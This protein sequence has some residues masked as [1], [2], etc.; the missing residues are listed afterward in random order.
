MTGNYPDI[1]TDD[2]INELIRR[3]ISQKDIEK[4]KRILSNE[5][6]KNNLLNEIEINDYYIEE[7]TIKTKKIQTLSTEIISLR[8]RINRNSKVCGKCLFKDNTDTTLIGTNL[9]KR[10][11]VDDD[12]LLLFI[13]DIH[14]LLIQSADWGN[15]YYDSLI[16]PV[17]EMINTY[18]NYFMHI[19]DMKGNGNGSKKY[20]RDI[21]SIN[22]EL[23]GNRIIK[24]EKYPDF[25][26]AI[27]KRIKNM[28]EYLD[29]NLETL[30]E[31]V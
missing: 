5:Q 17:L 30:L 10:F 31:K 14:K 8:L 12:S 22:S 7:A 9:S 2:L 1:S 6:I 11:V 16:L 24:K 26:I 25:Q 28:Y 13:N 23:I 15:L 3:E 19:I 21:A 29:N 4:A 27:L 18:R 20:Y